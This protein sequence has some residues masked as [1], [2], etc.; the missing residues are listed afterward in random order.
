MSRAYKIK[1]KESVRRV[2]R[3]RDQVQTQLELLAILPP[4]RMAELLAAELIARGFQERGGK[5]VRAAKDGIVI[6]IDSST[7]TVTVKLETTKPVAIEAER[8]MWTDET[9]KSIRRDE[10]NLRRELQKNLQQRA[11]EENADLQKQ[12]TDQL[13][14]QLDDIRKELDQVVNRVTAEALK[15][16]AAQIGHIKSLTEDAA[17]GSLTIVLEV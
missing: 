15:E 5:L 11:E 8:Q 10:E 3:A 6:E 16:K 2:V 14:R 13:E 9:G 4:E 1:I 17:T 12:V 7:A